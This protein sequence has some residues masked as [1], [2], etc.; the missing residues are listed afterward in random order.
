MNKPSAEQLNALRWAV[1]IALAVTYMITGFEP[2]LYAGVVVLFLP[3][4]LRRKTY[5]RDDP[6][7]PG[8]PR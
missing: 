2:A 6:K 4:L 7:D 8:E 1:T 3:V 5:P